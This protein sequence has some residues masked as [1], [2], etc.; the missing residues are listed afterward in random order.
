MVILR[1]FSVR[2]PS[3]LMPKIVIYWKKGGV[4]MKIRKIRPEELKRRWQLCGACYLYPMDDAEKSAQ[5]IYEAARDNPQSR[6][7]EHWQMNWA[8]YL[9][10]DSTM[11]GA[12]TAIPYE[13][14]FDGSRAAMAGIGGVATLPPYRREGAIRGCFEAMLPELYA[15]GMVFSYLYPFSTAY[16]R[17]FGYELCCDRV[18]WRLKLANVPKANVPGGCVL[19]EPPMDVENELRAVDAAWLARYNMMVYENAYEYKRHARSNPYKTAEYTYLYRG[20]D[21]APKGYFTWKLRKGNGERVVDVS[22]MAFADME[23]FYGLLNLMLSMVADQSHAEF[24][25]PAD[26]D[27]CALVPEWALW[28][29]ERRLE[30]AG[31][32][33]VVNAEAALRLCRTRGEGSFVLELTDGQIAEN[34]GRFTICYGGGRVKR[35]ERTEAAP[36]IAMGIAAFSRMLAGRCDLDAY[37]ALPDVQVL[38]D[39]EAARGIFYRKPMY[40]QTYF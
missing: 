5:E 6:H 14:Q 4:N 3:F 20:A 22:R 12:V 21:G 9:D 38:T 35:V 23:G 1:G 40:I 25:L 33:R 2:K 18:R 37:P 7:D 26:I 11:I 19:V 17:K 36:D 13:V 39:N 8:A 29:V 10:D 31:M 34:N 15:Q 32:V 24:V 27:L 16:Y 30:A 28:T